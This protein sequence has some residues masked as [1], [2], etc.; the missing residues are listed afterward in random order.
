VRRDDSHV[1]QLLGSGCSGG[2]TRRTDD[3]DIY[4]AARSTEPRSGVRVDAHSSLSFGPDAKSFEYSSLRN[5]ASQIPGSN[6]VPRNRRSSFLT[7]VASSAA[8]YGRSVVIAS[9][10]SANIMMREPSGMLSPLK[11]S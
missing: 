5:N 6:W 3:S 1:T 9:M 7:E 4:I 10:V 2:V 11:P 8:R